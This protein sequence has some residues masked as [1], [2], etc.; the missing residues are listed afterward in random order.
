M[1]PFPHSYGFS[2]L[3]LPLLCRGISLVWSDDPF[4]RAILRGLAA[5]GATVL[6]GVPAL[7]A[8]LLKMEGAVLPDSL[9]LCISAGAPLSAATAAAFRERFGRSIHSFYGSTEC[10]GI[11]YDRSGRAAD[12]WVGEALEG[13]QVTVDSGVEVRSEAVALGYFPPDPALSNG[14]FHPADLLERH[15]AGWR[16]IGRS[17]DLINVAGRKANPVEI[18]SCLRRLAGVE[19]CVVFGIEREAGSVICALVVGTMNPREVRRHCAGE[20]P[21]WQVPE[22]VFREPEVPRNDRGKISRPQ[23]A[24]R[25]RTRLAESI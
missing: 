9:R 6:P 17:S 23:L 19:D 24:E 13:V 20:L 10:G 7:F 15:A 2:N 1:I 14:A 12:G 11:C 18:E 25:Y 21:A 22:R 5:G 8:A 3:I 16:I 4:P